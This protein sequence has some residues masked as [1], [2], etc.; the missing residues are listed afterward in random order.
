MLL[1]EN[2][3]NFF[4][5]RHRYIISTI[6]L[7]VIAFLFIYI[8]LGTLLPGIA[9]AEATSAL[10]VTSFNSIIENPI[11]APHKI[12][13]HLSLN[14]LGGSAFAIRVV[15]ASF[16]AIALALLYTLFVTWH[17]RRIAVLGMA[18]LVGS[19]WFLNVA[20]LG[21][22]DI[23][24]PIMILVIMSILTYMHHRAITWYNVLLL[25]VGFAGI[26]YV[27]YTIY[28]ILLAFILYYQEGMQALKKV[29]TWAIPLAVMALLIIISPLI[30][31][32]AKNPSLLRVWLG[33][34]DQLPTIVGYFDNMASAFA[35]IFWRSDSNPTLHL[36]NLAMLDIFTATMTA[37]GLYH[38]ERHLDRLKTRFILSGFLLA[39][40]V[41]AFSANQF[42]YALFIPF[43]YI[44]A[45]TGVVT[46]INQWNNIFPLNPVARTAAVVP[47]ALVLLSTIS[48]HTTR[49]FIAWPRTPETKRVFA[50]EPTLLRS[51]II[52]QYAVDKDIIVVSSTNLKAQAEASVIGLE[53]NRVIKVSD[54][55]AESLVLSD[56]DIIYIEPSVVTPELSGQLKES[57]LSTVTSA[58]QSGSIAYRVY[59]PR[60]P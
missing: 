7:I 41:T 32:F 31:A 9:P 37:L 45:A 11:N 57:P 22:A 8:Q 28:F 40:F 6:F 5:Y 15:S 51:D 3:T 10:E 19:S 29:Q 4:I 14:F 39:F 21:T 1:F 20:R 17:R 34:P 30:Y 58:K 43:V 46:L 42:S 38:Y 12:L 50:T 49:Y 27:P 60:K 24:L 55:T 33:I 25:T 52:R 36:G 54:P 44:I 16:G 56:F 35:H 48:Y 2:Y 13:Q 47:I 18:L 23:L 53:E 26:L 59:E